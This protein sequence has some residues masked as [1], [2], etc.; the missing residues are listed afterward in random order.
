[1]YALWWAVAIIAI[2]SAVI[3]MTAVAIAVPTAVAIAVPTAVAIAVATAVAIAAMIS[4]KKLVKKT[5]DV[6]SIVCLER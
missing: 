2:L 4:T 5:H 3:A 6:C 1:L